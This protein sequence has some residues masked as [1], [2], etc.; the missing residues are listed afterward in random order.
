MNIVHF[1]SPLERCQNI[2][3]DEC[4]TIINRMMLLMEIFAWYSS[5]VQWGA[6]HLRR[7][8]HRDLRA[9]DHHHPAPLPPLEHQGGPGQRK[10]QL[11]IKVAY[12]NTCI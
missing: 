6:R 8:A 1:S 5:F 7:A 10:D 9:A 2:E 11:R 3:K 12:I 4:R